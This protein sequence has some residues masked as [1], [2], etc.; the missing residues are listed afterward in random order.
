MLGT[1]RP[2]FHRALLSPRPTKKCPMK[3]FAVLVAVSPLLL[4]LPA[5]SAD[6]FINT[7]A[8]FNT[9]NSID[10]DP[11]DN[12]FL[13]GGTIFNGGLFFDAADTG[14]ASTGAVN[15]ITLT[16]YGTGRATINAGNSFGIYS[17][18][19]GGFNISNLNFT[20]SGVAANGATTNTQSGIGFYTASAGNLKYD[21][22]YLDNLDISGFGRNGLYV[23][24]FNNDAGYNDVR[25]TNVVAHDNRNAGIVTFGDTRVTS[26][27]SLTNVYVGDS[28]AYNNVGD[29]A[30]AGNTGSGIVLGGVNGG[31]IERSIAHDNGQNNQ[32][33]QGPVGIWT[34]DSN[35]ITI[36]HNESYANQTQGGDGGG[37]DLDQNV[38][39]STLQYNYSHDNAGAG[40]LI[41]DGDG[42]TV[43]NEGNTVRY[44]ISENDGRRATSL[45]SAGIFISGNVRNLDVYNNTIFMAS[46]NDDTPAIEIRTVS[47]NPT[48]LGLYNNILYTQG[49]ARLLRVDT[50]VGTITLRGNDYFKAGE[51]GFEILWR[52][53]TYTNFQAWVNATGQEKLDGQIVG[54]NVDPRLMSPG[55]GGTV[56]DADLLETLTAY[57]LQSDSLLIDKGLDLQT[58]FGIDAGP[59]DFFGVPIQQGEAFDIGASEVP[60]PSTIVSLVLMGVLA[61]PLL[62]RRPRG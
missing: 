61:C 39:N 55:N 53:T 60:E 6:F 43:R 31:V 45:A 19:N 38:T 4:T 13:Q 54:L 51:T 42:T 58:L 37:F 1:T 30:S 10:F 18:D 26:R 56:G 59:H 11:G 24:G 57:M 32:P 22:I 48:N 62:G 9:L 50:N 47:G 46:N 29:P 17:Q 8:Q 40:Y 41:F 5:Q 34:Y 52:G 14:I 23:G 16:S 20:G 21:H 12:I 7:Q 2:Q 15:P 33:T 25:I 27:N 36:Q 44:N 49:T 3:Q 35:N 28:R